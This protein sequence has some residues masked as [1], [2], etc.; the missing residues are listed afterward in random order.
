MYKNCDQAFYTAYLKS[1]K[2]FKKERAFWFDGEQDIVEEPVPEVIHPDEDEALTD[3]LKRKRGS[4]I[5]VNN[6]RK[7]DYIHR[8]EDDFLCLQEELFP[9]RTL[10][11]KTLSECLSNAKNG[12]GHSTGSSKSNSLQLT[13]TKTEYKLHT[14]S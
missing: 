1:Q 14:S 10:H 2:H 3:D 8:H 12:S 13:V 5:L 11:K 4:S 6:K 7:S 9:T